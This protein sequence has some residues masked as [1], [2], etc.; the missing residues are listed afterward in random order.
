MGDS[1]DKLLE[2][3][4]PAGFG[5]CRRC[6]YLA[7]GFP[8]LC[9]RCASR[10]LTPLAPLQERCGV[11]D[12]PYEPG[13]SDRCSNE[14]CTAAW[15]VFEWN[16]AMAMRRGPVQNAITQYKDGGRRE[17][18]TVFGRI[19]IGFLEEHRDVF[20]PFDLIVATP[21]WTG[22]GGRAFDHTRDVLRAAALEA[23]GDWPFDMDEPAAVTLTGPTPRFKLLS[24]SERKAAAW[25]PY[26]RA[27]S[28]PEPTRVHGED[29]LVYDDVF[30]NG[31][32]LNEVA[33]A[34]RRAGA[35]SVSGVSLVRQPWGDAV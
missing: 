25:G 28:V 19:L 26:R 9:S 4:A 22:Y 32:V 3:A 10:S 33:R 1:L 16:Y 34:L 31:L 30:T 17:W 12:Q 18:A 21:T 6:K 24:L 7:T 13:R 27:L 15:R 5:A 23:P 2:T 20:R 29:V 8:A 11:C 35:S 14:A